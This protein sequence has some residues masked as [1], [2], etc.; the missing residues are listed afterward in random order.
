MPELTQTPPKPIDP[1]TMAISIGI[2]MDFQRDEVCVCTDDG[3]CRQCMT[4]KLLAKLRE[5]HPTEYAA[6]RDNRSPDFYSSLERTPEPDSLSEATVEEPIPDPAP[7][8]SGRLQYD[9]RPLKVAPFGDYPA[10]Y[11]YDIVT[12]D[13]GGHLASIVNWDRHPDNDPA[14]LQDR[15]H[16]LADPTAYGHAVIFAY[17]TRMYELLHEI[18]TFIPPDQ[19]LPE[20][21]A[22][23]RI[24]DLLVEMETYDHDTS[25]AD[26]E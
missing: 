6:A 21:D 3:T 11:R 8:P 26:G 17:G 1:P 15:P 19:D 13:E 18:V 4:E 25:P 7:A 23:A 20:A 2:L 22:A 16:R 9:R 14:A 12:R 10:Y 24:R 5:E